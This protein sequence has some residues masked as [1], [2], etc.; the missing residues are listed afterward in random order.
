MKIQKQIATIITLFLLFTNASAKQLKVYD[1]IPGRAASDH[2][3]C[4]VKF[5][6]E[7]DTAWR[8]A[9]VLQTKCKTSNGYF[10]ILHHWTASWIAFES[11]FNGENIVVEISKKDG[12]D[13]T[14]AMVR[15]VGDATPALI[16]NGKAYINFNQ[17]AN[18]N[19]DINGQMEKNYTGRDYDGPPVHTISLFA[20]PVYRV[21][22]TLQANVVTLQPGEDINLLNRADWDTLIFAPG[23]HDIGMPYTI[24]DNEVLYI[25]GDAILKGTIHPL[26]AWQE[27]AAQNFK[28]Y[29]T[30]TISGEDILRDPD[31]KSKK[32][33]PF[34]NQAE[35]AHLEG[36]VVA[37]PAFHTF[38]MGHS[39]E[40]AE[41][42][43]I[44]K[45]L[46]ILAWRVNSD[47]VNAFRNSIVSECFFRTQDDAFYLGAEHVHQFDNVVWNDANGAVLFL[48]SARDGSSCTFKDVKV[49]YH[50]AS[51]HW[52]SGG[53]IISMRDTEPGTTISNVHI[54]NVLVED[55]LPAFP[56]FYATMIGEGSGNI[57]LNNILIE[58]V[59]QEYDGAITELD[60]NRGKPQNTLLGLDD[61]RQW[62]NITFRNCYFNGKWLSSFADGNFKTAY[63]DKNTVRFEVTEAAPV[64]GFK[65]DTSNISEGQ[66]IHFTDTSKNT[67][68]SWNWTFEGGNP[69]TSTKRNPTVTYLSAGTYD[70]RLIAINGFGTD[71]INFP[72]YISVTA[73][74]PVGAVN[75]N[76][77][78]LDSLSSG[79]SHQ[80]QAVVFPA[81][82]STQTVKWYSL[83]PSIA[84][85]DASGTL[86]ALNQGSAT[87]VVKTT[88]GEYTDSCTLNITP[89]KVDEIINYTVPGEVF[90]GDTITVV[91]EYEVSETRELWVFIQQN[92]PPWNMYGD[93]RITVDAGKRTDN[94]DFVVSEGIPTIKNAYK[95]VANILPLGGGWPDR[96]DEVI[97]PNID[98]IKRP[99]AVSGV[100]IENCPKNELK[101]S[102]NYQ[103]I[104]NVIPADATDKTLS[105]SSSD[106]AV[107][108][109]NQEGLVTTKSP[110]SAT[111]IITSN[112]GGFTN[113]C[114]INVVATAV[115]GLTIDNC[116]ETELT[117][118]NSYQ[119]MASIIPA[120]A[121]DKT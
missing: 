78:P 79:E 48:Q 2:Y 21:P 49:I 50:R 60:G 47:G 86:Y 95:I 90:P 103:L 77:C 97:I 42:P 63:V 34:T 56:P 116:P 115:N 36:F 8:D 121:T 113:S 35:A 118:N 75:I 70:V 7:D 73:P 67:P 94:I 23:V 92:S 114:S 44:Y 84:S 68:T 76:N 37:D 6:S 41:N 27:V 19:V 12:S 106:E 117:E 80:F 91:V 17:P 20:N 30:G 111:V 81:N 5:E 3:L 4:R 74:I 18:V 102:D 32:Y 69:A 59:R 1:S 13:I 14:E 29:G 109:V 108:T 51:W 11:D 43:N 31:D 52:W 96:L 38:N 10:D 55:P 87:I 9:F 53:R 82:A 22:D 120:D 88:D 112:D 66:C 83:N 62:E 104:A 58:N 105:W 71:T 72:D 25:P 98:A 16:E 64:G 39:R 110:G 15:P 85:I 24:K 99:V 28:V 93:N 46:K 61:K 26:E 54:Q 45:N 57:T 89:A 33:K 100:D 107:L 40:G 119:L 65:V 101:D